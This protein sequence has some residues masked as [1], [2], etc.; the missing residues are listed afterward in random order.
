MS[1]KVAC[2]CNFP[3]Q[4]MTLWNSWKARTVKLSI[5]ITPAFAKRP[6]TAFA[7][8]AWFRKFHDQG[9]D[10]VLIGISYE[11]IL[12]Y[13]R[14][15][16]FRYVKSL[17]RKPYLIASTI[18]LLI[19][20]AGLISFYYLSSQQDNVNLEKNVKNLQTL[21]RSTE[22]SLFSLKKDHIDLESELTF[23]EK[24]KLKLKQEMT[25]LTGSLNDKNVEKILLQLQAENNS[26]EKNVAHLNQEVS[27]LRQK[28]IDA[29]GKQIFFESFWSR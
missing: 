21:Q 23:L 17:R 22:H 8:V 12:D 7:K 1:H 26:L 3:L 24:E 27:Y 18:I 4:Q 25:K 6:I 20:F 9:L 28:L 10:K 13:D 2:V 16:L 5:V 14:K 11:N 19:T 15:V 29:E